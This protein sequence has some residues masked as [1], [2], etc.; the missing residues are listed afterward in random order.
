MSTTIAEALRAATLRLREAGCDRPRLDAELLL[1]FAAA[2][3][4]SWLLAHDDEA[5]PDGWRE[6][7]GRRAAREPIAYI[8]QSQEFYGVELRVD[9]RVLIPRPDT[10]TLV[11]A[12]LEAELPPGVGLDLC[13][14]S[15]CVAAALRARRPEWRVLS[16]DLSLDALAVAR[17]NLPGAPLVAGNGLEPFSGPFGWIAANPPYV[18]EGERAGLMPDVRDYE[19]D[20]AL[21][22]E[23]DGRSMLDALVQQAPSRLAAGGL[24]VLECA[25][26]QARPL[27]SSVGWGTADVLCD[28]AGRERVVTVR[29]PV[30]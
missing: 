6:L 11:D 15:G 14:G 30:G 27:A 10:E 25:P 24:L 12:L 16:A 7:V 4:R 23:D 26:W 8:L 18:S 17:L 29:M 22:A 19:P 1:G 13:T 20:M 3:P 21:F 9:S 28:L 5:A 2:R